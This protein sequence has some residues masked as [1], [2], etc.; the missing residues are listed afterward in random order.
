[1]EHCRQDELTRVKFCMA[2]GKILW[3]RISNLTG[4]A[5]RRDAAAYRLCVQVNNL[6][7]EHF[8]TAF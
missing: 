3:L 4:V 7:I 8:R 5:C 2:T 6:P 1:M